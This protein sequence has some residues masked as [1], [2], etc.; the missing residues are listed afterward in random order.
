MDKNTPLIKLNRQQVAILAIVAYI[1]KFILEDNEG[2]TISNSTDA[3]ESEL[4]NTQGK[5][6]ATSK[7]TGVGRFPKKSEL[8]DDL[9]SI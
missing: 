4:P 7:R 1:I 9:E 6:N 3:Q 5:S 8:E 2:R